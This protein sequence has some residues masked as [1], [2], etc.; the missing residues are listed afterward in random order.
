[1]DGGWDDRCLTRGYDV[2][3]PTLTRIDIATGTATL[4]GALPEAISWAIWSVP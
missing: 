1:M 4:L 3:H 2:D